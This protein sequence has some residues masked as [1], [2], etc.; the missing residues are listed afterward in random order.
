ML[1]HL[2]AN[3]TRN[4]KLRIQIDIHDGIPVLIGVFG[5]RVAQNMSGIVYQN[6]NSGMIVLYIFDEL[7][8]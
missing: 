5:N 8:D 2:L 7:I 1:D 6:I 3:F 4:N